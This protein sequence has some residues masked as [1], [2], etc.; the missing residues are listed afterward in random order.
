DLF[1][2]QI[3]FLGNLERPL[4]TNAIDSAAINLADNNIVAGFDILVN[5]WA[6][7]GP[8]EFREGISGIGVTNGTIIGNTFLS[9]V[10]PRGPQQNEEDGIELTDSFGT[11]L[12]AEN[13]FDLTP[14]EAI[15]INQGGMS[16]A[17][18]V[19][20][21]NNI[22]PGEE[23]ILIIAE[24]NGHATAEIFNNDIHDAGQNSALQAGGMVFDVRDHALLDLNIHDNI[25][26][27]SFSQASGAVQIVAVQSPFVG[28]TP[29]TANIRFVDN[30]IANYNAKAAGVFAVAGEGGEV[31][32][33][34]SDNSITD[35]GASGL[36]LGTQPAGGTIC[37]NIDDNT[38]DGSYEVGTAV[39]PFGTFTGP[40]QLEPASGNSGAF[41]TG[42]GVVNVADGFCG[43]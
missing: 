24:G 21:D 4:I 28:G 10:Q 9:T 6:P 38:T 40:I 35:V 39:A 18:Y 16:S 17:T 7:N 22:T 37:A 42:A 43:F 1:E 11:F 33:D 12:I 2:A 32:L 26:R 8:I 29:A 14:D 3:C 20:R 27:D 41:N 36:F 15:H 5:H 31:Q 23:G 25:I 13:H 30:V 34:I 19:I